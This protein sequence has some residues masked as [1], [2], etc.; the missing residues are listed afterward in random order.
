MVK[1]SPLYSPPHLPVIEWAVTAPI[2]YTHT[3]THTHTH[4]HTHTKPWGKRWF[5]GD[6]MQSTQSQSVMRVN[7]LI[8]R[9]GGAPQPRSLPPCD[10]SVLEWRSRSEKLCIDKKTMTHVTNTSHNSSSYFST[11][12]WH[13]SLKC[14]VHHT[15]QGKGASAWRAV[16][17]NHLLL[18]NPFFKIVSIKDSL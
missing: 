6:G 7:Q 8:D 17:W 3:N 13:C 18:K 14:F 4:T 10:F 16:Y 15:L 1:P 12:C 11:K 9:R 5:L 2:I